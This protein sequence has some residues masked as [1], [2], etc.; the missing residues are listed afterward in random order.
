[1]ENKQRSW[2]EMICVEC[3]KSI[4]DYAGNPSLWETFI[5]DTVNKGRM[6]HYHVG[7]LTQKLADK[8]SLIL[9]LQ[10]QVERLEVSDNNE[11]LLLEAKIE[12]QKELLRKAVDGLESISEYWNKDENS[13]AME[14]ACNHNVRVAE[15]TLTEIR[16]VMEEKP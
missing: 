7:C 10:S 14:D 15:E 3:L 9:D 1:M 13:R 2:E 16:K 4:E 12:S 8:D 5:A 11:I 6:A